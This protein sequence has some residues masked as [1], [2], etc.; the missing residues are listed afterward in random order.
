MPA[1]TLTFEEQ[2]EF[3]RLDEAVG[4]GV[5]ASKVVMKAGAALARIRDGQ[6]FRDSAP[7]WEKYLE[8]HGLTRRRADQLIQAARI[9]EGVEEQL[10]AAGVKVDGLGTMTESSARQLAGLGPKAAAEAV[11]EAAATEDGLTPATL[12][13]AASK[14][15]PSK[16]KG[17]PRPVNLRVPGGIVTVVVN[18]KGAKAGV[19][20]ET[21]LEAALAQLR[22]SRAA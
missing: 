9:I 13:A 21:M 3:K 8:G 4:M 20:T 7:T 16:R 6:L 2:R 10:T 22:A 18:G 14:R 17:I 19:T 11:A 1:A 15:R 12:K 5:K